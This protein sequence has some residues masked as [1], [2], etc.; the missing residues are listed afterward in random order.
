MR[1]V[2]QKLCRESDQSLKS[3]DQRSV[4]AE[5]VFGFSM[6]KA[7]CPVFSAREYA[8]AMKGTSPATEQIQK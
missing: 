5:E 8:V 7:N 6:R 4:E 2:R 1:P 3:A